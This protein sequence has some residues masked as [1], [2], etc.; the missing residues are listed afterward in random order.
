[1]F[2]LICKGY[3]PFSDAHSIVRSLKT[4]PDDFVGEQ[5]NIVPER[6]SNKFNGIKLIYAHFETI[7]AT[8]SETHFHPFATNVV[9]IDKGLTQIDTK[10]S[11]FFCKYEM[12]YIQQKYN[13]GPF[14]IL[15]IIGI[16]AAIFC[17]TWYAPLLIGFITHVLASFFFCP[18]IM[19]AADQLAIKNSTKSE[20]LG[21]YRFL[22][23]RQE[24]SKKSELSERYYP[25]RSDKIRLKKIKTVL[26]ET[27][28]LC[29]TNFEN[30]EKAKKTKKLMEYFVLKSKEFGSTDFE[31]KLQQIINR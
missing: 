7:S 18:I 29:E 31:E 26:Q 25:F 28:Q 13:R 15:I 11:K 12:A 2:S 1:M 10:S 24:A 14:I 21:A 8:Y 20:L 19:D 16:A 6:L 22:V 5:E 30:L 4:M 3:Y 27:H 23:A 17:T 9:C